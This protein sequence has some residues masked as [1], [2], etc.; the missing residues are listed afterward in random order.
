MRERKELL[1][2]LNDILTDGNNLRPD[3]DPTT[4]AVTLRDIDPTKAQEFT[5]E[6]ITKYKADPKDV[7]A[8]SRKF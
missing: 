6:L 7:A 8:V 4:G 2:K 5:Q 1:K 3:I